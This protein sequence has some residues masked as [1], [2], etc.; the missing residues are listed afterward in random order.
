MSE[1]GSFCA[2][3]IAH[4]FDKMVNLFRGW[5]V[6]DVVIVG[7]KRALETHFVLQVNFSRE[8]VLFPG[9]K[10]VGY[11]IAR[12]LLDLPIKPALDRK[13]VVCL[14]LLKVGCVGCVCK[15]AVTHE[16]GEWEPVADPLALK[17][18]QPRWCLH[19]QEIPVQQLLL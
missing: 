10:V 5:I 3:S 7:H 12:R 19:V 4:T 16:G 14:G 9:G 1:P 13:S 18:T 8:A 15:V 2:F 6:D 11:V 17:V